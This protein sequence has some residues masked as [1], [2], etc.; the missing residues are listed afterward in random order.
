LPVPLNKPTPPKC[1]K[2]IENEQKLKTLT[3]PDII[4]NN[5]EGKYMSLILK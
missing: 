5:N 2:E 3:R 1:Q 4:K